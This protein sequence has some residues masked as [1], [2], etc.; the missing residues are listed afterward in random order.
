MMRRVRPPR[1]CLS[2]PF[3]SSRLEYRK[4]LID[5]IPSS[6]FGKFKPIISLS[7]FSENNTITL[8]RAIDEYGVSQEDLKEL[9]FFMVRSPYEDGK[10]IKV[11]LEDKVIELEK[12]VRAGGRIQRASK[13]DL[14][15]YRNRQNSRMAAQTKKY[16]DN[17][18]DS[19]VIWQFCGNASYDT[20]L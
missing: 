4:K 3:S 6:N 1:L 15:K 7:S 20:H 14:E 12:R 5:P 11:F 8:S 18:G 19:V 13:N 2:R 17:E 9:D 16:K 10:E